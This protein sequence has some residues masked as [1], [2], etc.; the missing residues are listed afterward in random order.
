VTNPEPDLNDEAEPFGTVLTITQTER[1]AL[2][3]DEFRELP[4]GVTIGELAEDEDNDVFLCSHHRLPVE[5]LLEVIEDP[6]I[7]DAVAGESDPVARKE[8]RK[9][10]L[11]EA[12][13]WAKAK[14]PVERAKKLDDAKN[15]GK[16]KKAAAKKR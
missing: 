13:R 16:P 11:A 14:T 3:W 8:R 2:E 12:Q 9:D 1:D 5:D 7:L 6:T 10:A 15:K 4:D